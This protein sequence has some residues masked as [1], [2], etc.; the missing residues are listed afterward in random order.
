MAPPLSKD[1]CDQVVKWRAKYNWTYHKLAE[2]AGCSTCTVSSILHYHD[3]YGQSTNLL[4]CKTGWTW[5]LG[6]DN[7]K[8]LDELALGSS[9]CGLWP[10][11]KQM[12]YCA[13]VLPITTYGS[14]LWLY[15]GVA[16]HLFLTSY[17]HVHS[18]LGKS[19]T[20]SQT[21]YKP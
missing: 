1:L 4:G 15:E 9:V 16:M 21:P 5:L 6:I 14:R 20:P 10:K 19:S 8:Y 17:S 7:L 3:T 18:H 11:H 13:C 2:V 12:L